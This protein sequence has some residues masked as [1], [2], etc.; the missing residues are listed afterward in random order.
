MGEMHDQSDA[1]LLRQYAKH[2]HEAAFRE[3][4]VR[5]TDLVYFSALRQVASPDLARDVTQGV[6]TDLVRK[7]PSLGQT[8]AENAS[9]VGWLYR[10]TR[11]AALNQLR[12]D[13]RR[14]A[15]ERQAMENLTSET[16]TEWERVGPMLDEA[17]ADLSDEDREALLLRFFKNHDFRTIGL[18]LGVSDDAA[19]KRVSRALE[20][21]R[22]EFNRRGVTTTSVALSTAVSANAVSVAPAGLAAT[23]STAALSGTALTTTATATKA[24]TMTTLQKTVI[25]TTLAAAIGL[26]LYAFYLGKEIRSL[27]LQQSLLA[28]QVEELS[29]TRDDLMNKIASYQ[30]ESERLRRDANDVLRLRSEVTRLRQQQKFPQ[31]AAQSETNSPTIAEDVQILTTAKFVSMPTE[32]MKT[33]GVAWVP[34]VEGGKSGVLTEEQFKA[35]TEAMQGASDVIIMGVPR[36]TT[37]NGGQGRI[38]QTQAVQVSGTNAN[39]G[40][41]LNVTSFFSTNSPTF[42]L[43]LVAELTQL[44]G[45]PSQPTVQT[46]QTTNISSLF[47]GQILVLEKEI[48]NGGWLPDSTNLPAGPRSLLVFITPKVVDAR[49]FPTNAS[50]ESVT[51]RTK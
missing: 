49:S 47:P 50:V 48:P 5:H 6:F 33:L 30:T 22:A 38:S 21:L 40:V 24:I 46:T 51:R 26:A 41:S 35:L 8:L 2:G 34:S 43:H 44:I 14:Q 31:L 12:D 20:R 25:A 1:Q 17:M 3:I 29:R 39:V 36:M 45:D 19:Q 27:R 32:D 16:T 11:F 9:L 42:D 23:F 15:R 18:S 37:L 10:S 28:G 4:V 7:A 13:R